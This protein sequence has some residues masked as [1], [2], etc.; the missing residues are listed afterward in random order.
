[1]NSFCIYTGLIPVQK[2]QII[3]IYLNFKG[4]T[5]QNLGGGITEAGLSHKR[6]LKRRDP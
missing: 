4:S 5:I 1:M 2:N 3:D 6:S